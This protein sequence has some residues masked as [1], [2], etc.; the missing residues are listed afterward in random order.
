[1]PLRWLPQNLYLRVLLSMI[2]SITVV[3]TGM[4][5]L[6]IRDSR[7][8]LAQELLDRGR[9]QATIL[10]S[11]SNVYLAEEESN[12]LTLIANT[13]AGKGAVRFVAFHSRTGEL[14]AAAAAPDAPNTA[15]VSF[16]DLLASLTA[17]QAEA[18][19][20]VNGYMEIAQP[21]VYQGERVGTIALRIG[22]ESFEAELNRTLMQSIITAVILI[23]VLSLAM[24]VLLRQ[25]V[26]VPLRHLSAASEQISAGRWATPLEQERS[27]ELGKV[28]R[29]FNQMIAVLQAREMQLQEHITTVQTLNA[30]LDARVGERTRE[31]HELVASQERLLSQIRQMSTPV[32][33][34]L[35]GVLVVPLIGDLDSQ[36]AAQFIRSV[37]TRIEEHR[38][39]LVIL[40]IT[41]VPIMDTHVAG[42]IMRAAGAARLLGARTVLVG[43]RPEVAQ[44]LVQIGVDL[45]E[46]RTFA[47][48]Q[49]ALRIAIAQAKQCA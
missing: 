12:Q 19:R 16:V 17:Q 14:L 25:I 29:S 37:L 24:G 9:S 32:V 10:A 13:T 33:P 41:G 46:I 5:L 38:A 28:A 22:T 34:V 36:R 18:V 6:Q 20:W 43:I 7:E 4:T 11:A 44:T 30:E 3:L 49:E 39:H 8:Q 31:L 21:I 15:R 47:T 45:F 27:D 1:M 2:A 48:L 35:D 26:I 23:V 42:V 40:D